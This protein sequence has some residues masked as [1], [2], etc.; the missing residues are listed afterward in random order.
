MK[1]KPS[2]LIIKFIYIL[3][4]TLLV[5]CETKDESTDLVFYPEANEMGISPDTH[6]KI[7]FKSQPNIGNKGKIK[8]FDASNDSLVDVLDLSIPPG[9]TE[10]KKKPDADY[11]KEPYNYNTPV[12]TNA[13]TK[14]GTP[15]GGA[16]PTSDDYQLTIIGGFSDAFHFYPIIVHDSTAIIYPHHNLL[17][18]NKQYYVLMDSTV[19]STPD[20]NFKGIYNKNSWQFQTKK[21]KPE[22]S[23]KKLVVD[24]RGEGDFNTLQGALDFIPEHHQDTIHISIKNGVYEEL[25]YFRN[26]SNIIIEGESRASTI[27]QYANNEVFNPHPRNLKTNEKPGTFPSRRAAFAIDNCSNIQLKNLTVKTL[28]KGQAEGLLINGDQVLVK[29]V[30]IVGDGDA[31]QTNGPAYFEDVKIDGGGDMILGR[32]PAFFKNCE[33][34]SPGPFMWI[35]NTAENHGNVFL[36]CSFTNTGKNKAVLARTTDNRGEG[37]PYC[38]AVLLNCTLDGIDPKGWAVRGENTHSIHY[39]EYNST[40]KTSGEPINISERHPISRQLTKENDSLLIQQY[41]D[42]TFVLGGWKP[43]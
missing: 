12:S 39:W 27:V 5:S 35:R 15:S 43:E 23:K 36:N 10:Y 1:T 38:E 8:I 22:L 42:P 21:D 2:A 25:I 31:L 28:L 37:Y 34:L 4:I 19:L 18:Y 33:F 11:I 29:N 9:P 14:P 41:T 24:D 13:N 3:T 30:T 40:D 20:G 26:K 32:G 17:H 16:L 6:L 7:T